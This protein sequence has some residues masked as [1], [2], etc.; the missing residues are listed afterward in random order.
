[1]GLRLTQGDESPTSGAGLRHAAGLSFKR[2]ARFLTL[3]FRRQLDTWR[4][5]L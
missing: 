4:P 1:M 2:A 5:R 3:A